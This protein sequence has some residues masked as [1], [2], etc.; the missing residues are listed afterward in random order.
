DARGARILF[1]VLLPFRPGNRDDVLAFRKQP[2]QS[3][4]RRCGMTGWT[5]CSGQSRGHSC[6]P[7]DKRHV[8]VEILLLKSR[9]APPHV[10]GGEPLDVRNSSRQKPAPN[11]TE[12][13]E[14][15]AK[16]RADRKKAVFGLAEPE[17]VLAL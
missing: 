16:L 1:D 14:A 12:G 17:G 9:Q 4:L 2:R 11:R 10:V 7:A 8:A 5:R 3:D 6:E 13:H 15:N